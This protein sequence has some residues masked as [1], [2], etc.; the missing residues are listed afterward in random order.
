MLKVAT[1][2]VR[3]PPVAELH[4]FTLWGAQGVLPMRVGGATSQLDLPSLTP[5]SV[6]GCGRS[7]ATRSSPL[8]YFS[9]YCK[10]LI[11]DPT[12]CGSR[13]STGRLLAIE[14][15]FFKQLFETWRDLVCRINLHFPNWNSYLK[16]EEIWFVGS[17][18]IFPTETVIWNPKRSGLSDQLTFSQLKQLFETWRDLNFHFE[19]IRSRVNYVAIYL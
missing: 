5:L 3:I 17:T 12:F 2:H 9:N 19:F 8:G 13:F 15:F 7:S 1:L 18:C 6:A 16:P 10:E 11:I 4:R 14:D